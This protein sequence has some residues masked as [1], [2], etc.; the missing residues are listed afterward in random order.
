MLQSLLRSFESGA[1]V[2]SSKAIRAK[3]FGLCQQFTSSRGGA[4]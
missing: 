4:A 2:A 3:Q 1:C